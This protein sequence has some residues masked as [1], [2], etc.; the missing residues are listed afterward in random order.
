[1]LLP[2]ERVQHTAGATRSI[3]D[4]RAPVCQPRRRDTQA[5]G[6]KALA[7]G[8]TIP[9]APERPTGTRFRAGW[10]EYSTAP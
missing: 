6:V 4:L 2:D 3:I 5:N 1:M 7:L 10:P 8:E 9:A